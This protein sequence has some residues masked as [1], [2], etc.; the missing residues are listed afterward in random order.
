MKYGIFKVA[1]FEVS[2]ATFVDFEQHFNNFL[3]LK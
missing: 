3:A 1:T 2:V